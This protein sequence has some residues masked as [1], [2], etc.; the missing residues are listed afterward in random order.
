MENPEGVIEFVSTLASSARRGKILFVDLSRITRISPDAILLLL[1]TIK[2]KKLKKCLTVRG[3]EPTD[4][5]VRATFSQSGFYAYVAQKPKGHREDQSLG[6]LKKH[7]GKR[8]REDICAQLVQH[9]T[10]MIYGKPQKN[11]GIYRALIEC[12]AN[13]RDHASAEGKEQEAW[14]ASV[15]FDADKKIARFA[16]LDNGVGIFKSIKWRNFANQVN[17]AM[18]FGNQASLL[19]DLLDAELGSRTGL[20]YR[21]KGLPA[22]KTAQARGHMKNLQLLTNKAHIN[23]T[24]GETK[25]L[26]SEFRGTCLTWEIHHA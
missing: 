1:S 6:L 22:I 19:K 13:T 16:F 8:V 7:E 25:L 24:T 2:S 5:K 23:V 15:D 9:A 10:K 18:L 17:L 11:G 26:K 14:W 12:M 20:P 4:P 3:N 21:G